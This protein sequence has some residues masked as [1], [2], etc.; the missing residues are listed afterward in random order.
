M[1]I[2]A[3]SD[4]HG[5]L[6]P[7]EL[8]SDHIKRSDLIVIS[9]DISK[10][11][12]REDADVVIKTIEAFNNNILAV[13]GN[14]DKKEV[15]DFLKEKGYGIHADG[16]TINEIGFFGVG[17]SSRTPM[18]TRSEYGE[19]EIREF[20]NI[21]YKKIRDAKT[22]IL[23]SH[24]P[25][26]GTRDRSFWGLRGGS[27]SIRQFLDNNKIH[28]CLVGHIHEASGVETLN[29]VI[30]ANPGSFKSG[31]YLSINIGDQIIIEPGRVQ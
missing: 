2:F 1:K 14:M 17:G 16:K 30:V 13:H 9:G 19:D 6:K 4:I 10:S 27:K 20:L 12:T 25:P 18:N 29:S 3:I 26:R 31:R 28:L 24:T 11:G 7:I 21:G 22:I 8:A 15:K 5:A 23:I